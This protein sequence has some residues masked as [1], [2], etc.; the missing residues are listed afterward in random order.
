[1]AAGCR[2]D[3]DG[4][5]WVREIAT[6]PQPGPVYDV[7]D[8]AGRLIDRVVIPAGSAIAGFGRGGIVYLGTR[9]AEGVHLKRA[10][11]R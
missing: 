10:T 1:V 9:D 2:A 7:I 8:R 3:A 4:N 11:W 6:S 5:V